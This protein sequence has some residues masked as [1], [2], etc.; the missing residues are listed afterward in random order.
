MDLNKSYKRV[1]E[2]IK[3]NENFLI[4]THVFPDGDALGSSIALYS[5]L[6]QSN[7]N[8]FM[9]C[10][11]DLPYQY[12]FLPFYDRFMKELKGIKT[13]SKDK[14]KYVSFCLNCSDEGRIGSDFSSIRKISKSIVNID[15]HRSN[16]K[17]GDINI[18]D[19]DKAA[20]SEIL[21]E[22]V[23]K[24]FQNFLNYDIAVGIYVG[25]L[26]DSGRFQY[27][28]T[29]WN[30]HK[31]ASELLK[32]GVSPAKVHYHVYEND[33]IERFKLLQ[34]VFQRIQYDPG[35]GL[36]YSYILEQDFVKLKL[37]FSSQDGII[38]ILRSA[39]GV[40]VTVLIKEMGNN[41]YKLSLRTS[42][43]NIN[44]AEAASTAGGGGHKNAA[45]YSY[46]GSL[47]E[48]IAGLKNILKFT[49][50]SNGNKN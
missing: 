50:K 36:L 4:I 26:T 21:Y 35:L 11:N 32:L 48:V 20:T 2:V 25:I 40:K 44:L 29:T 33:P 5:L 38:E 17:F 18:I 16:S 39:K 15:H 14:D 24:Q 34:K 41:S 49:I 1:S 37:P 47:E 6:V 31:I 27:S 23:S 22:L 7:K 46:K 28:S 43:K 13:P 30:I 45:A 3:E 12:N 42:D 10:E 9:I 19:K 8:V